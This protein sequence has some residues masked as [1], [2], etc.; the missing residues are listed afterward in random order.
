M[1]TAVGA[2]VREVS[3]PHDARGG[4][5]AQRRRGWLLPPSWTIRGSSDGDPR[6]RKRQ[7][8]R[9]AQRRDSRRRVRATDG[10]ALGL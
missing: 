3:R 1:P 7:P 2:V 9:R 10:A 8:A 4:A 5:R 6:L